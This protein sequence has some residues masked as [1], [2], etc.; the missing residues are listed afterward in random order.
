M[1]ILGRSDTCMHQTSFTHEGRGGSDNIAALLRT[2]LN[3]AIVKQMA[4]ALY[5]VLV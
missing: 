1:H 5:F 3:F 4:M 2:L